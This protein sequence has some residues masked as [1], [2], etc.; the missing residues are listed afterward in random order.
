ML[1]NIYTNVTPPPPKQRLLYRSR[2]DDLLSKAAKHSLIKVTAGTG[3]GKTQSISMF[4]KHNNYRVAWLQ[5][6]KLDNFPVRFWKGF[7]YAL[8]L[9]KRDIAASL[10]QLAFPASLIEFDR[11]LHVFTEYAHHGERLIFVFDD[12]HFIYEKSVINFIENL[13]AAS[14]ENFCVIIISRSNINFP[15]DF[16]TYFTEAD[17]CFSLA[18]TNEYLKTQDIA[19][20]GSEIKNIQ[21]YTEGWP[22]AIYLVGLNL[23]KD[24]RALIDPLT[25][26][27]PMIFQ[28]IE[29]EIFS[30]YPPLH[31]EFLIKLSLLEEFPA[32][33]IRSFFNESVDTM[34]G[35][36]KANM[37]IQYNPYTGKYHLH[38][39]FLDFLYEK[40]IYLD[41]QVVNEVYLTAAKWYAE[42][43]LNIDAITY[44]EKCGHYEEIWNILL[45]TPPDRRPKSITSLF[46]RLIDGF[47]KEFVKENPMVRVIRASYMHNNLELEPAAKTLL[48]LIKEFKI[49][50]VTKENKEIMGEAY[51]VLAMIR[52]TQKDRSYVYYYK[53]ADACL[54]N[55]S[56]RDYRYTKIIDCNNSI[57]L[58]SL[59]KKEVI[60]FQKDL[61]EAIPHASRIMHGFGYGVEYLASAEVAYSKGNLEKSQK[62]AFEAIYRAREK[63]QNDIVCNALFLLMKITSAKGN[64]DATRSYIEEL[65][66]YASNNTSLLNILDIAEGWFFIKI[67]RIEKVAKWLLNDPLNFKTHPPISVG[68]DR[69]VRA[70]YFLEKRQYDELLV[71]SDQI[72]NLYQ[73][74]GL[75]L[76][77]VS[78][79]IFNMISLY[80]T[81]NIPQ[82][83]VVLQ[84]LYTLV[85]ENHFIMQF[86]EL[87][88]HMCNVIDNIK[89]RSDYNIPVKWLDNIYSKSSTYAKRQAF[90]KAKH[91]AKNRSGSTAHIYLTSREKE[92]FN[93]LSQGLTRS[94]IAASLNISVNTVKST[95]QNIYN[96]LGAVNSADAVRIAIKM[97]LI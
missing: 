63:E 42:K 68:R 97:K 91:N 15:T 79:R 11:F 69:L 46:I 58:N 5:L 59:E 44:Y 13:V 94:E 67:G 2:L 47:P 88:H 81:G 73:E 74:K 26:T 31:Q 50:P 17:L 19:L 25:G 4:L 34:M 86:I 72:D 28:L 45:H 16:N 84:S 57:N 62:Y 92:I 54:P 12:F 56:R 65:K 52:H 82:C 71:F 93:D 8:S 60:R 90:Y 55:G 96:K 20:I 24:S 6:S 7:I 33:L 70:Y 38:N 41:Q 1:R 51:I 95:L 64:Y 48:D 35:I 89:K 30:N 40:H 83:A 18:E 77:L 85:N 23:K 53:M 14:I 9:Q 32:G 29:K 27:K 3:Y 80:Y 22:L 21:T 75:W 49:L 61:F 76:D 87:G 43:E 78:I 66:E 10:E 37:F 39:I 36:L